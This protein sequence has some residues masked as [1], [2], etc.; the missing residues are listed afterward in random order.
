[1]RTAGGYNDVGMPLPETI[2]G[3]TYF[4]TEA[5]KLNLSYIVLARYIEFLDF[6]I[7]GTWSFCS[8]ARQRLHRTGKMRAT[9]HDVLGTFRPAVKHA[10]LFGN[11]N[12]TPEEAEE[13]VAAGTIDGVFFGI[14][15]LTHPDLAKRVHHGKPLD[16][17]PDM[18]TFYDHPDGQ[19][20][21][22]YTDYPASSSY[23]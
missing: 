22:G 9:K 20:E 3:Y 6:E 23:D 7:D 1:V 21:R 11:G 17:E 19:P 13:M 16:N 8:S 2:E 12:F 4:I 14:P 15:C 5:D 10:K 18:K